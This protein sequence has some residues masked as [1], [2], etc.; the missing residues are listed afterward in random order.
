MIAAALL[1][2]LVGAAAAEPPNVVVVVL[3]DVGLEFLE[4]Y[5]AQN[6]LAEG[7]AERVPHVYPQMPTLA[8]LAASGVR[9]TQ[10]RV[11]PTC[12]TT[13]ATLLS[14]RYA[15]RHGVG[16]L[17]RERDAT[18]HNARAETIEFGVGPG[19]REWTI[20]HVARAAKVSSFLCGKYHLALQ[21][22]EVALGGEPGAGWEHITTVAGFD[23]YWTTWGNLPGKPAPETFTNAAGEEFR[24]GYFNFKACEDG[25]VEGHRGEYL[26]SVHVDRAIE[27]VEAA[28]GPFLLFLPFN[29]AH[30]PWQLPPE[31]LIATEA[32]LERARAELG[33][34]RSTWAFYCAILE[35]LDRE[36]G[37]LIDQVERSG[38]L[39]RTVFF[40]LGD[41]GGDERVLRHALEREGL[42]LGPTVARLLG[43][44]QK[45]FKHAVFEP[46]VRVPLIVSGPMVAAPGRTSD[47]LVDA[48]DLFETVRDLY[49]VPLEAVVTDE[50]ALDGV[51]LLPVL[52]DAAA[53][54]ARTSSL[55][56]RFEPGGNPEQVTYREGAMS[57]E[58][59]RR[60]GFVLETEAG[61]FKLVRNVDDAHA[62]GDRLFRLSDERGAPVDPWELAPIPRRGAA[63]RERYRQ[64]RAALDE[65]LRSEPDN[66]AASEER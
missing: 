36:L 50:R 40:V 51:S 48:T 33:R 6:A 11:N 60:T 53:V 38:Q 57:Q 30:D 4:L 23:R 63:N 44:G 62:G 15:F 35:A 47:A 45:R 29:A 19:N 21:P 10:F 25:R 41:N 31:E 22:G 39:E 52:R 9:F 64:V 2:C 7:V 37:R 16:G 5:D 14:G 54:H 1:A 59:Q 17:V 42:D 26:T 8:R 65:L 66:W 13:R 18:A 20:A 61:R 56:E 46:G 55:V 28:T 32:Y 43:A 58:H 27:Y 12:A 34:G 3:D 24:P 49:G